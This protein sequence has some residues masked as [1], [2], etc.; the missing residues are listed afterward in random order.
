MVYIYKPASI[1]GTPFNNHYT[2]A[3]F[4]VNKNIINV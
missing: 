2:L 1:A 3:I 4:S